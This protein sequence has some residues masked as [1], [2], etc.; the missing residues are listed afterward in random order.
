[1]ALCLSSLTTETMRKFVGLLSIG[2]W[3]SVGTL[4]FS[5]S[6]EPTALI[7]TTLLHCTLDIK[8]IRK[9]SVGSLVICQ[10]SSVYTLDS[11]AIPELTD[12]I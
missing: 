4:V 8:I 11:S 10:W 5:T 12:L 1:M 2:Q 6:P 3:S 9:S 7:L